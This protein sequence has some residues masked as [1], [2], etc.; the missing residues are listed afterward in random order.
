MWTDQTSHPAVHSVN[1]TDGSI[2]S[3]LSRLNWVKRTR[4]QIKLARVL[5][6][7]VLSSLES[8]QGSVSTLPHERL[9]ARR[10][11]S[12]FGSRSLRVGLSN[13][14]AFKSTSPKRSQRESKGAKESQREPKRANGSLRKPKG[15]EGNQKKPTGRLISSAILIVRI[16]IASYQRQSRFRMHT[17]AAL[18][19]N[20]GDFQRRSSTTSFDGGLR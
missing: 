15:V 12:K 2:R 9:F 8:Q 1:F 18:A 11:D 14:D 5:W 6:E 4:I 19:R 10:L 7:K 13:L 16:V 17:R 3:H 20:D